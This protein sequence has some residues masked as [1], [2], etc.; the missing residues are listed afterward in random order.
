[1]PAWAKG[2]L[3]IQGI[4]ITALAVLLFFFPSFMTTIWPW[5]VTPVLAQMYSGPLLAYGLG[6]LLFS[7]EDKWL[8]IRAILPAMFVFTAGTVIVSLMHISLFSFNQPSDLLWFGSFCI[9][10]IFLGV[11]S[12]RVM[13]ARA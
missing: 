8:G 7:R 10:T 1:V 9:A 2:F 4:V 6:S 13:Q 12:V 11:L 5:K 3:L